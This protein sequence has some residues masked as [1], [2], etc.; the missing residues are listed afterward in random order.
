MSLAV[1]ANL[2]YVG[3]CERK[4][5]DNYVYKLYLAGFTVLIAIAYISVAVCT[6]VER[7]VCVC[8]FECRV[9]VL[10]SGRRRAD[11]QTLGSC[12]IPSRFAP[13]AQQHTRQQS[14]AV[15]CAVSSFTFLG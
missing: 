12:P 6:S 10:V 11:W 3:F 15:W 5:N 8:V 13:A 4:K 9:C 2:D 7:S 14:C 1:C